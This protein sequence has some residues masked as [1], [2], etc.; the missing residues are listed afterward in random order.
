[1][2]LCVDIQT[3]TWTPVLLFYH[4]CLHHGAIVFTWVL[5]G[6]QEGDILEVG[7]M[8]SHKLVMLVSVSC[9]N[10][11]SIPWVIILSGFPQAPPILFSCLPS[12]GAAGWVKWS[13]PLAVAGNLFIFF[14]LLPEQN[15]LIA[16]SA[17][18][19]SLHSQ[20]HS[21]LTYDSSSQMNWLFNGVF[22]PP[23]LEKASNA[24]LFTD[25]TFLE[26]ELWM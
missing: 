10:K 8:L 6:C 24:K 19:W 21:E 18:A 13:W 11:L 12:E 3:H 23:H 7:M 2:C 26:S 16:W 5:M 4:H 14:L 20:P 15:L 22:K 9:W 17:W 25:S 1:M